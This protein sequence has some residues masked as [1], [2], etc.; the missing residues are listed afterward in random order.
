MQIIDY[1]TFR[2]IGLGLR[3]SNSTKEYIEEEGLPEWVYDYFK[4]DMYSYIKT[5]EII[6]KV[7]DMDLT[8][9]FDL[10]DMPIEEFASNYGIPYRTIQDWKLENTQ[11]KGYI[12][13]L[14]CYTVYTKVASNDSIK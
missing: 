2:K 8:E 13:D 3:N 12:K 5:V 6:Q 11:L 14:L 9:W 1:V 4:D 7:I 10:I